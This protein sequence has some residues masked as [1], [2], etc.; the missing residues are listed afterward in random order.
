MYLDYTPLVWTWSTLS[1][2]SFNWMISR[3]PAFQAWKKWPS[4]TPRKIVGS[5]SMERQDLRRQKYGL[6]LWGLSKMPSKTRQL[7][8]LACINFHP[9]TMEPYIEKEEQTLLRRF[10]SCSANQRKQ[11]YELRKTFLSIFSFKIINLHE[12]PCHPCLRFDT[13]GLEAFIS[14]SLSIA[15]GLR[16]DQIR[17]RFILVVPSSSPMQRGWMRQLFLILSIPRCFTVRLCVL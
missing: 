17:P 2:Q 15:G 5:F 14:C 16:L 7:W 8:H 12:S 10:S 3:P 6:W 11:S 4:T 9:E 13:I 1:P